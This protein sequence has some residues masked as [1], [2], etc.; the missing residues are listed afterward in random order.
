MTA[1]EIYPHLSQEDRKRLE[2]FLDTIRKEDYPRVDAE[3]GNR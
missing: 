3:S 1:I 2:E